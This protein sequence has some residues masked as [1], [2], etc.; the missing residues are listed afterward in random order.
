MMAAMDRIGI[1]TDSMPTANPAGVV[2]RNSLL[3]FDF[4][5]KSLRNGQELKS[6]VI[7][8]TVSR[9]R[10]I[11]LTAASIFLGSAV[12]IKDPLFSGLGLSLVFGTVV[13]TIMSLFVTPVFLYFYL[14]SQSGGRVLKE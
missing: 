7:E 9:L 8:C 6:A 13:A 4:V 12:L 5:F 3:I 10:P 1:T 11:V 2:V 14:K